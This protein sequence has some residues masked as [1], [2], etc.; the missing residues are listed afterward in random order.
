MAF[1]DDSKFKADI[2]KYSRREIQT[3]VDI[4][5]LWSNER[6]MPLS[7]D[8]CG[9]LHCGNQQAPNDYIINGKPLISVT[10]CNDLGIIRSSLDARYGEQCKA[11][12]SQASQEAGAI[13]RCFRLKAPELLWPAFESYILPKLM[14]GVPAWSPILRKDINLIEKIRKRFTK[15]M[16]S[17]Q[18]DD[19]NYVSYAERLKNWMHY[20]YCGDGSTLTWYLNIKLC[21]VLSIFLLLALDLIKKHRALE[22]MAIS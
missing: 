17:M 19:G 3:N 18:D 7:L 14:Y 22:E 20:H 15:N 1:A 10:S 8:K 2:V 11:V 4:V 12:Y 16:R 5:T 13:R 6:S 21:T 9:I